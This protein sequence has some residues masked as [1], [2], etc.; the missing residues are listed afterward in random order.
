MKKWHKRTLLILTLGALGTVA[1]GLRPMLTPDEL[2]VITPFHHEIQLPQHLKTSNFSFSH[3]VNPASPQRGTWFM[4][5]NT[6]THQLLDNAEWDVDV[7]CENGVMRVVTTPPALHARN[8]HVRAV[9]FAG[10]GDGAGGIRRPSGRLHTE[11]LL[12]V[13]CMVEYTPCFWQPTQR[14]QWVQF[15]TI[16]VDDEAADMG[17]GLLTD[18]DNPFFSK[19]TMSQEGDAPVLPAR[20]CNTPVENALLRLLHTL[21]AC[22][23]DTH[24]L[25]TPRLVAGAK[26]LARHATDAPWPDCWGNAA[27]T[28]RDLAYRVGPTLEYLNEH[29]CFGNE[30][31]IKFVNSAD[32][33]RIFG[34]DFSESKNSEINVDLQSID[35]ERVNQP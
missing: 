19:F 5:G 17:T 10:I 26:L 35:I 33:S 7:R 20:Y 23:E 27:G 6:A 21:A 3:T 12:H 9:C 1:L 22:T 24:D 31:L 32:F 14:A 8:A 16:D 18:T 30:Q 28:A 25:L 34:E 29:A 11:Y 2:E 15:I 13:S 4:D